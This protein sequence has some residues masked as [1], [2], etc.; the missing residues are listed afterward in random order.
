MRKN[1]KEAR[2]RAGMTQKQVAEYL[3]KFSVDFKS[4]HSDRFIV[5]SNGY[6]FKQCKNGLYKLSPNNPRVS[7]G[8]I[9]TS[10]FVDGKLKQYSTHR[11]VAEAFIPNPNNFQVVNHKDGDRTNNNVENL[12]WCSQEDNIHHMVNMHKQKYLTK[13]K[14]KRLESGI[15]TNKIA[16]KV[17]LLLGK[18]RDIEN[19]V[20]PPNEE[21]K[22]KLEEY[23][24]DS[25]EN[26]L[27]KA[28][29]ETA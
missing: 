29:E 15:T 8:Y 27:M 1:L 21:E 24:G 18:Y 11:L 4:I 2:Q 26:L 5:C 17:G 13:I 16:R 7:G 10:V 6:V 28:E 3:E 19:A 12:E 23:F 9:Y 25:I 22:R 20:R 14:Q